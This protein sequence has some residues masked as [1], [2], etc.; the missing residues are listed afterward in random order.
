MGLA[1]AIVIPSGA[2]ATSVHLDCTTTSDRSGKQTHMLI[3]LDEANQTATVA[4][5]G[6]ALVPIFPAQFGADKVVIDDTI[7]PTAKRPSGP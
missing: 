1:A 4:F 2:T 5:P 3:S 6:C 7:V